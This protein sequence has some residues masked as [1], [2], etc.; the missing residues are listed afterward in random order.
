MVGFGR[1]LFWIRIGIPSVGFGCVALCGLSEEQ[2]QGLALCSAQARKSAGN[3]ADQA[4]QPAGR[5]A[6]QS[7]IQARARAGGWAGSFAG[8]GVRVCSGR[9]PN[10]AASQGRSRVGPFRH[11]RQDRQGRRAAPALLA[12]SP[13][14]V[15]ARGCR[16]E[17]L[18]SVSAFG[19]AQNPCHE[20]T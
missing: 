3:Q 17:C 5:P 9:P 10:G 14:C 18:P 4:R 2:V 16:P 12:C 6:S 19:L 11:D 8:Q 7:D 13:A 1:F 15:R 20:I